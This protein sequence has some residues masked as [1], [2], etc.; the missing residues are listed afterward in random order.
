[1]PTWMAVFYESLSLFLSDFPRENISKILGSMLWS[2]FYAIFVNF[3][4]MIGVF[5][6]NQCYDQNFS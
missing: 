1:M 6:K 3:G 2:Q 4:E 5:L